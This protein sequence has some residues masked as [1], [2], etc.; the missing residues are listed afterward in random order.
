MLRILTIAV[1]GKTV[2]V[3][4][5]WCSDTT[6]LL[7]EG[8]ASMGSGFSW[9]NFRPLASLYEEGALNSPLLWIRIWCIFFGKI[10][11]L[12][13]PAAVSALW[14]IQLMKS[15]C[16]AK[17]YPAGIF[18]HLNSKHAVLMAAEYGTLISFDREYFRFAYCVMLDRFLAF[19]WVQNLESLLK[20][21]H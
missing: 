4:I 11:T 12:V 14:L 5:F 1:S 19:D 6:S 3:F 10:S 7:W 21:C 13:W 8:V 15:F 17:V 2:R 9:L 20:E 18:K 16:F